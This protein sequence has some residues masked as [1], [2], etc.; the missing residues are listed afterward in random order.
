MENFLIGLLVGTSLSLTGAGGALLAIPLFSAVFDLPLKSANFFSLI[1]VFMGS[2]M[3]VMQNYRN[4]KIRYAGILTL[5]SFF[6][7]GLTINFKSMVPDSLILVLLFSISIW[8]LVLTWMKV[9]PMTSDDEGSFSLLSQFMAGGV[10]G[11]LAT[12]TGI[13]GGI[14]LLPLIK[15]YFKLNDE[16][17]VATSLATIL[18]SSLISFLLQVPGQTRLP[19][20]F[21]LIFIG[22]G[23]VAA[24]FFIKILTQRMSQNPLGNLRKVTYTSIVVYALVSLGIRI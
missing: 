19:S 3:G 20:L 18:L 7:S 8:S 13:G 22:L 4:V 17:S 2:L 15:K 24:A 14:L 21:D 12:L 5:G 11:V 9:S 23:I 16:E 10:V 1:A 6:G